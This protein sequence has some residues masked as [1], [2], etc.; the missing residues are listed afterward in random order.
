MKKINILTIV[1]VLLALA[2]PLMA[3]VSMSGEL[4]VGTTLGP[5]PD[6]GLT[7]EDFIKGKLVFTG[8]PD[9]NNKAVINVDLDKIVGNSSVKDILDECYMQSN[10]LASL[11]LGDIPVVV[12]L[13]AGK[14]EWANKDCGN[15]SGYEVE[16]VIDYKYEDTVIWGID[17]EIMEKVT[18]RIALDPDFDFNV[19]TAGNSETANI[20]YLIGVFGG[21]GPVSAELM[22]T[23]AE[24]APAEEPGL[25]GFGVGVKLSFGDITIEVG[26]DLS[27][28]L[29]EGVENIADYGVGVGFTYGKLLYASAG[30]YGEINDT[31]DSEP[32]Y[33]MGINVD[34]TPIDII[35]LGVGVVLATYTDAPSVLDQIEFMIH[36]EAG[37]LD[38]EAGYIFQPE[39]AALN[40]GLNQKGDLYSWQDNGTNG[41]VFIQT[42]LKF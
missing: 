22:Y 6:G 11:G 19:E 14:F 31:L 4:Y 26:G 2:T 8:K 21:A 18:L 29:A 38:I 13:K 20:G 37:A 3:D 16:D 27:M 12:T 1:I 33:A 24:G 15:I 17:V 34:V 5:D 30:F 7:S 23:N 9:D 41:G 42:K 39:D 40:G 32:L 28:D 25:F 10:L 36:T 35:E